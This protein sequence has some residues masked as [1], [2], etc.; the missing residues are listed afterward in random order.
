MS[1]RISGYAAG[2]VEIA[3]AEGVLARVESELY[4]LG[5]QIDSSP[6]LRSTLTDPQLPLERKR[7]VISDL[8]SGRAS[9]L[10]LGLTEFLLGQDL[11]SELGALASALA[12]QAAA[13]R[14]RQV[15][16]IRSAVPLDED[17][18]TRLTEALSRTTGKTLEVRS[19]VDP[20]VV[21]GII[22]RVGDTVIDGSVAAK[23]ESLRQ[24]LQTAR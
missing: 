3:R 23:L 9:S 13:S 6:E 22:A 12:E 18:L 2:I 1:D 24:A 19:V 10:T 8:L 11:G 7:A 15:A 20:S 21:G 14:N 16:E 17:T 4:E 5:R